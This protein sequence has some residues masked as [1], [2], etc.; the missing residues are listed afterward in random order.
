MSTIEQ[1]MAHL[2]EKSEI[3]HQYG[4]S[5]IGLFGSYLHGN[6]NAD[7]DIDFL[8]EF[9]EL[10]Y[11]NYMNVKLLLED[12]F[13]CPVDLVIQ[14]DLRHELHHVLDEVVYASTD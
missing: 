12:T 7:S 11:N 8:V 3:L 9:N 2:Q 1:I 6:A 14:S 4:V 10:S 13:Q 5:R